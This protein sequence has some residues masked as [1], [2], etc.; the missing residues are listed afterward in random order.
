MDTRKGNLFTSFFA[1]I[2]YEPQYVA[3]WAELG[4]T[5]PH[6]PGEW[7]QRLTEAV[8]A[9]RERNFKVLIFERFVES[10]TLV[11]LYLGNMPSAAFSVPPSKHRAHPKPD[12]WPAEALEW[13]AAQPEGKAVNALYEAGK[14]K[15]ERQ[16]AEEGLEVVRA[17]TRCLKRLN[18]GNATHPLVSNRTLNADAEAALGTTHQQ[19]LQRFASKNRTTYTLNGTTATFKYKEHRPDKGRG[20]RKHEKKARVAKGKKDKRTP[21]TPPALV[22]T[23][24]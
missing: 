20:V 5:V 7:V 22:Q 23:Q 19:Q 21:I 14:A 17:A 18:A 11:Q 15:F 3:Q 1:D 12:A 8:T 6:K 24:T 16:V 2:D 4:S 13:F 10:L 9:D